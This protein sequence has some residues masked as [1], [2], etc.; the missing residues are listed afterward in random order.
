MNHYIQQ[1]YHQA[2]LFGNDYSSFNEIDEFNVKLE[3]KENNY[4]S[5]NE[6]LTLK[7]PKK[8]GKDNKEREDSFQAIID[9][10]NFLLI[11]LKLTRILKEDNFE[12]D[13]FSLDDKE[14]INEFNKF[15]T[16]KRNAKLFIH[17]LVKAKYFLDNY[18]VH[19]LEF[20]KR[21]VW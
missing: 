15:E 13:S 8:P 3:S 5:L 2:E 18:I 17:N 7:I 1:K 9:F 11:V 16:T 21:T 20:R 12:P 14:L 4:H 19:H 6:L 10:P